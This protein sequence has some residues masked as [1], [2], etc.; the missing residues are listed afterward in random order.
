[1]SRECLT[2]FGE[3]LCGLESVLGDWDFFVVWGGPRECLGTD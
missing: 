2:I 3:Y 1:V